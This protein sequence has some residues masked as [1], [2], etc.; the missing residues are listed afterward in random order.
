VAVALDSHFRV[1]VAL[2]CLNDRNVEP[3]IEEQ[4][5]GSVS[6]VVEAELS[7]PWDEATACRRQTCSD[8]VTMPTALELVEGHAG[9]LGQEVN[10]SPEIRARARDTR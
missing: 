6:Q 8:P 2:E 7:N 9:A 5:N 3:S 4:M 1:T 10:T